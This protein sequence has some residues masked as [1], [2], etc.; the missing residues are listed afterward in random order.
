MRRPRR[1]IDYTEQA[2]QHI[3]DAAEDYPRLYDVIKSIELLLERQ[4][5]QPPAEP[6]GIDDYWFVYIWDVFIQ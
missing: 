1:R 3:L 2:R 5:G 4:P 6:T